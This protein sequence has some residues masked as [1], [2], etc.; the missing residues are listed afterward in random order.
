MGGVSK[1]I[2]ERFRKP[3]P[4]R[5]AIY[6]SNSSAWV[7]GPRVA[8]VAYTPEVERIRQSN[9]IHGM[10]IPLDDRTTYITGRVTFSVME[11]GSP[12]F[13]QLLYS[14]STNAQVED[15]LETVVSRTEVIPMMEDTDEQ[16]VHHPYGL[17]SSDNLPAPTIAINSTPAGDSNIPAGE[18]VFSVAAGYGTN[19]L[20]ADTSGPY[21]TTCDDGLDV[22]WTYGAVS[23][24][25][26]NQTLA[27]N[28][29]IAVTVTKH[30]A[31]SAP[32]FFV[33]LMS[34]TDAATLSFYAFIL[35]NQF[36]GIT[37]TLDTIDWNTKEN[38]TSTDRLFYTAYEC[39][40]YDTSSDTYTFTDKSAQ[41][42]FTQS[43]G[44]LKRTSTS[45]ATS[46]APCKIIYWYIEPPNV[47][48]NIGDVG[49]T[50][51][52]RRMQIISVE[53]DDPTLGTDDW[54]EEGLVFDFTR[55]NFSGI[56]GTLNF[57]DE[58]YPDGV[59]VELETLYDPS[60]GRIGTVTS[61]S[62]MFDA[63]I[64]AYV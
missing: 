41:Y 43:D 59:G 49:T 15:N 54:R 6:D 47:P 25:S 37:R 26:G 34:N 21:T 53:G 10:R 17:C 12:H 2:H 14:D 55:V 51:D 20:G 39:T 38:Y 4:A 36:N 45:T 5:W 32:D 31:N 8:N 60:T 33:I 18:Y 52:F 22:T 62:A 23:V 16:Y 42:T 11:P 30:A 56:A 40:A 57:N 7:Q 28:D 3:G 19:P 9:I 50:Q 58:D 24:V 64:S 27:L 1:L 29:D 48:T 61:Y 46:G 44:S 35:D 63:W 13:L